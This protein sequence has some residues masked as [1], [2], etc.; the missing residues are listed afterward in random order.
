MTNNDTASCSLRINGRRLLHCRLRERVRGAVRA[1]VA[2][3][4]VPEGVRVLLRPL[5]L[6]AAG[7]RREPRR[8]PLLRRHHHPRRPPQVPL[9]D[10][11][12][13]DAAARDASPLVLCTASSV[14]VCT[15]PCTYVSPVR[16]RTVRH[17]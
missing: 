11:R 15:Q 10:V 3:E 7:H 5:Q 17:T 13:G 1:V 8:L 14:V 12:M 6:R 4:P 2:V 16:V 9:T